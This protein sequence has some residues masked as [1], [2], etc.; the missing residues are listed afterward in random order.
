MMPQHQPSDEHSQAVD[1]DEHSPFGGG[2]MQFQVDG[3]E[4]L[5][6]DLSLQ[7][8][9]AVMDVAPAD[10]YGDNLPFRITHN[11]RTYWVED[12]APPEGRKPWAEEGGGN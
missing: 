11:M 3:D 5:K 10:P 4:R 7:L 2:P 1:Q 9:A 12:P 6:G 8:M